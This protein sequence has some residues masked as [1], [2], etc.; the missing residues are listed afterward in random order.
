M[1]K[2]ANFQKFLLDIISQTIDRGGVS[3]DIK[4]QAILPP[5]NTWSF[6]KY[7]SK[8]RILPPDL[9]LQKEL[10]KFIDKNEELLLEEGCFLGIWINPNTKNYYLDIT[11]SV[12]DL[13]KAKKVAKKI[14]RKEGRKI[15]SIYNSHLDKTIYLWKEVKE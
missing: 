1:S 11:T 3:T 12:E 7:P 13:E 2:Q 6:P 14:S 9:D 4:S 10:E 15:V 5:A 8:T